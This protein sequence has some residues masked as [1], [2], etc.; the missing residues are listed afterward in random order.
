MTRETLLVQWQADEA[1]AF[2]GWDFSYL[3]GR[4]REDAP[5]WSYS[6]IVREYL[7]QADSVLDMGTGG[8]EALLGFADALPPNTAATEGWPPNIPIARANLEPHGMRVFEYDSEQDA[9]MPFEDES[10]ALVLNRHEA[11][12]PREVARVLKPGGVFVTQQVDA[13]DLADL[14]AE[15][16]IETAY[17]HV[18]LQHFQPALAAAGLHVERAEDWQGKAAF[19][20]VGALVYFLRA[21]PWNAPDDFA[22]A[23]YMDDLLRFELMP[24]PLTYTIGRF[25]LVAR[26]EA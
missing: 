8:G 14:S 19:A 20:D 17:P 1:Q 10:F 13:R 7:P 6:A 3:E 5:P 16:F 4:Y 12:A 26:K 21:V 2:S 18:T 9:R 11:Y 24:K 22:V 25:L 23:R 15:F